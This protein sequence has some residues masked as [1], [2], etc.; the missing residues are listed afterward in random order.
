MARASYPESGRS[1]WDT[2][3]GARRSPA[4]GGRARPS[5]RDCLQTTPAGLSGLCGARDPSRSRCAEGGQVRCGWKR[6][7]TSADHFYDPGGDPAFFRPHVVAPP[8]DTLEP[9]EDP[10]GFCRVVEPDFDAHRLDLATWNLDRDALEPVLQHLAHPDLLLPVGGPVSALSDG[11]PPLRI[12]DS[13][14]LPKDRDCRKKHSV[15]SMFGRS[16]DEC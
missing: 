11:R 6:S 4:T 16:V 9:V 5:S 8:R 7:S 10:G 3:P 14:P 1:S 13:L 15:R 12:R 2:S